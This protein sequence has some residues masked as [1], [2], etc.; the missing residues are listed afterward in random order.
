MNSFSALQ[1]LHA[2][3]RALLI[4][5]ISLVALLLLPC[6]PSS[7][8][9]EQGTLE[10]VISSADGQPVADA[11]VVI[12][13][14]KPREVDFSSVCSSC[15][16]ECGKRGRTNAKGEFSIGPV[17]AE[18]RYQLAVAAAGFQAT[19]INNAD[20]VF[21]RIETRLQPR[22][23][24]VPPGKVVRGKLIGPQGR[25][26]VAATVVVDGFTDAR[27]LSTG[28]SAAEPLA[29]TDE[30]GIF[31]FHA[32][33]S[34]DT[35]KT[36]IAAP[37]LAP[38]SL[39]LE[40]DPA[41]LLR[42]TEGVTIRGRLTQEGKPIGGLVVGLETSYKTGHRLPFAVATDDEGRFTLPHIPAE[43]ELFLFTR[44]N[45]TSGL[46]VALP[47]QR[48]VTDTNGSVLDLGDLALR[49]TH[50][51]RGRLV[52]SDGG[53][54]P[55]VL[56][57]VSREERLDQHRVQTL[58]DGS[59]ELLSL[60]EDSLTIEFL[61]GRDASGFYRYRLSTRNPN[62]APGQHLIGRLESD[63][64]DFIIHLEPY[65]SRND[66]SMMGSSSGSRR[67]RGA[68]L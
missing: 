67:L 65:S 21:G 38:R 39:W 14:A 52:T 25:P 33:N 18:L 4:P 61:P 40:S 58:D 10:G 24:S 26:V 22:A 29:L 64:E 49:P 1:T 42:L 37:G 46:E 36:I 56:L 34:L 8:A 45:Q 12:C 23:H 68:K 27:R 54:A 2:L 47:M 32:T 16:P 7:A 57:T 20:A 62:L 11:L 43:T 48:L 55:Q 50:F 19:F 28:S 31:V 30:R 5:F 60:P 44:R 9:Q 59:F 63:L 6:W 17:N 35:I 3:W 51:I 66:Q 41:H 15:Y 53:A 13:T